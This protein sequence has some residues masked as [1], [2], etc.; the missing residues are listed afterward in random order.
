ML[1]SWSGK[2]FQLRLFL[3]SFQLYLFSPHGQFF[4]EVGM[5]SSVSN[6]IPL[7]PFKGFQYFHNLVCLLMSHIYFLSFHSLVLILWPPFRLPFSTFFL[8]MTRAQRTHT[9]NDKVL[10]NHVIEN[11]LIVV[12]NYSYCWIWWHTPLTL[13]LRRQ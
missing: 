11:I 12:L 8:K 6:C 4:P 10:L 3:C 1:F 5:H 7:F 13:V 9:A 2:M